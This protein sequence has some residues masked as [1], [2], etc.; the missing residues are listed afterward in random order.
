VTNPAVPTL[1]L[2]K[3]FVY[4]LRSQ[5]SGRYYIGQSKNIEK[6]LERHNHGECR[7]TKAGK[8]WRL[9][10]QEVFSTRQEAMRREKFL[11]SPV[12]WKELQKIKG[13]S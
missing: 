5:C 6:R 3:Y 7:S 8:P 2:M 12:G 11:K 10:Y 4:I 1:L 9:V 13:G